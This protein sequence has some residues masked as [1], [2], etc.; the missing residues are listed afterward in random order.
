[1]IGPPLLVVLSTDIVSRALFA[2]RIFLP[3]Q[4][5]E[6]IGCHHHN[7]LALKGN[8]IGQRLRIVVETTADIAQQQNTL[9][10]LRRNLRPG[11]TV[12]APIAIISL[13]N[14]GI[15]PRLVACI[16]RIDVAKVLRGDPGLLLSLA[17]DPRHLLFRRFAER[18][19]IVPGAV[20]APTGNEGLEGCPVG[21]HVCLGLGAVVPPVFNDGAGERIH[22]DRSS[23]V[24]V[25]DSSLLAPNLGGVG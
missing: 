8:F 13:Q 7:W 16:G 2:L 5:P 15:V 17:L 6:K 11:R 10:F 21:R 1:M 14:F 19:A 12:H 4:P 23:L 25:H 9:H 18:V 20:P 24:I 22:D 3:R